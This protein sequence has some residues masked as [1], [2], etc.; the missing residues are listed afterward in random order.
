VAVSCEHGNES[1]CSIK[2]GE[3]LD[4]LSYYHRLRS[5]VVTAVRMMMMFW[6]L[7]PC[8]LVGRSQRFGETYCLHPQ[9]FRSFQL[10]GQT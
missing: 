4:Q 7:A 5:E 2:G 1:S 6:V 9:G 3:F 10:T 8:R